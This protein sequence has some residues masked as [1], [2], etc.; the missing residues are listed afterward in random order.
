MLT[1]HSNAIPERIFNEFCFETFEIAII[2]AV[3][4]IKHIITS[5]PAESL[6]ND[7][8]KA[9]AKTL[10]TNV[11]G[12]EHEKIWRRGYTLASFPNDF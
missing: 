12:Q 4:M 9:S 11:Q 5:C 3:I 1:L 7:E 10:V 6:K 2:K 8:G